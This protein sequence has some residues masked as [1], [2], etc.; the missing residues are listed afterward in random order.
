[1]IY[2]QLPP[3]NSVKAF[4]A[5]VRYGS[6]SEA[7][8]VLFVNQSSI[9]RHIIKLEDFLG[10]K[11]L[12]RNN[13][14]TYTTKE[15]QEYFEKISASLNDVLEATTHIKAPRLGANVIRLSSLSSFALKWLVP[16]LNSFQLS[17]PDIILDVSVSDECPDFKY[18]EKDCAIIS[19]SKQSFS[20]GEEA[21]FEE[22]LIV[23]TSPALLKDD[24]MRNDLESI[25]L[26]HTTSR[27]EV[28]EQW[29]TQYKFSSK[30]KQLAG[31]TFQ[32]F[33]ISIA[34]CVS[35]SGIALVPSFLV[36]KELEN[37]ILVQVF[38]QS[39]R[40]EKCYAFAISPA[41]KMNPAVLELQ[42]WLLK[43]TQ[44]LNQ[45]TQ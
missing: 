36:K 16:K 5:V 10:C 8:R 40:T 9:S 34:A 17:Y 33:Y 27:L 14:G 20:E 11:L 25:P 38:D 45:K 4:D 13:K 12:Q 30:N 15:G 43:E 32:D 28:W 24:I 7:A 2:S 37:K 1:M 42:Q 21:L 35:G 22:E 29:N 19:K 18:S 26:I 3:L 44:F 39:L 41:Q 31:L 6:I 23:V